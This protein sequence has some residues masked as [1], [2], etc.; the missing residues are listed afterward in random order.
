MFVAFDLLWH[1]GRLLTGQPYRAR[2]ELLETI[3]LGPVHL[4][5]SFDVTTTDDLL[6]ACEEQGMEGVVLKRAAS[7]YRPGQ[8]SKDWRKAKCPGWQAH[9]ERR[10]P[11]RFQ[12]AGH[13]R[14]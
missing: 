7:L 14:S 6:G 2:R 9:L 11:G 8:R 5:P 3:D 12:Q 4:I 13:P 10:L 1:D